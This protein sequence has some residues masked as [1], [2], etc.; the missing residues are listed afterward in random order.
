MRDCSPSPLHPAGGSEAGEEPE[1]LPPG[2]GV[3]TA[4]HREVDRSPCRG[5]GRHTFCAG[6]SPPPRSHRPSLLLRGFQRLSCGSGGIQPLLTGA[7]RIPCFMSFISFI[8]A[9][10]HGIAALRGHTAT[11]GRACTPEKGGFLGS[12]LLSCLSWWAAGMEG[13]VGFGGLCPQHR[14]RRP[15]S[16]VAL[17]PGPLRAQRRLHR[18]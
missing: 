12:S 2:A 3:E 9:G 10:R 11:C 6:P 1:A 14:Q 16:P 13:V 8:T 15:E 7:S 4:V 17:R 5:G 18:N